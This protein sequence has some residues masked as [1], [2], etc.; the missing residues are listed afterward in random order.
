MGNTYYKPDP[1]VEAWA[2]MRENTHKYFRFNR[3]TITYS[4]IFAVGI[5]SALYYLVIRDFVRA[6]PLPC[7]VACTHTRALACVLTAA[8]V[9]RKQEA[10]K[11]RDKA[12]FFLSSSEN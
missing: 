5:P 6:T 10:L 1:A 7:F 12:S 8:C 3:S 4:L 11:G 2:S 9:Q